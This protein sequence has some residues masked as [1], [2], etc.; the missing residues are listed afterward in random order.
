MHTSSERKWGKNAG[1]T[2]L[3]LDNMVFIKVLDVRTACPSSYLVDEIVRMTDQLSEQYSRT[4]Y[5]LTVRWI[6]GHRGEQ[7]SG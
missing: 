6:S 2:P 7:T 4:R 3:S 5:S 1:E